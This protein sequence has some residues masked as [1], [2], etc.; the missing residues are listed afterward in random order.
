M[1][2][3]VRDNRQN[4][5]RS[6]DLPPGNKLFR[7]IVGTRSNYILEVIEEGISVADDFSYVDNEVFLVSFTEGISVGTELVS[8][9]D[10]APPEF[11]VPS[12]IEPMSFFTVG[13]AFTANLSSAFTDVLIDQ[14]S[15]AEIFVAKKSDKFGINVDDEVRPGEV[16]ITIS[17]I[18]PPGFDGDRSIDINSFFLVGESFNFFT[19]KSISLSLSDEINIIE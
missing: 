6:S 3:E 13:E 19:F 11:T 16:F 4:I 17:D 10:L 12:R 18:A 1:P 8:S 5:I 7:V 9:P 2:V 14:V 15:A